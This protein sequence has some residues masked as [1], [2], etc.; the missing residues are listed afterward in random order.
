MAFTQATGHASPAS[1]KEKQE[2]HLKGEDFLLRPGKVGS[3][4][5]LALRS[6]RVAEL[7]G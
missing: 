1:G 6:P 4:V 7:V 3:E 2:F 5:R